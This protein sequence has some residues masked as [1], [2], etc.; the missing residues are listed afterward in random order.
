MQ[1]HPM[2]FQT[3]IAFAL[4]HQLIGVPIKLTLGIGIG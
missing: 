3:I 4:L 1:I 2:L